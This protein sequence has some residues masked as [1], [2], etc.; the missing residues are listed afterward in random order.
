MSGREVRSLSRDEFAC[1]LKKQ[2]K[3]ADIS[4]FGKRGKISLL[5]ILQVTSPLLVSRGERKIKIADAG[6]CWL[7]IVLAGEYFWLT[8]M[9]DERDSFL[10]LYVDMTEGNAVEGDDASFTDRYLDF[11]VSEEG[12]EALDREELEQ[13]FRK[14]LLSK[15]EY[16]RTLAEGERVFAFLRENRA[17]VVAWLKKEY[18]RMK[19][20]E[21]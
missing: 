15:E 8:A 14:G 16:E 2:F 18:G 20:A 13:A 9:F 11:V 5:K 21:S 1:I 3:T 4:L 10:E 7:Q 12:V 17:A 6:Y 19:Y